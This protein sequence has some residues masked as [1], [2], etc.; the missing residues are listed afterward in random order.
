MPDLVA[1]D[2]LQR[3]RT[4]LQDAGSTRW[5]LTEL[6]DWLND[7]MLDICFHKPDACSSTDILDLEE[8][9]LQ[10]LPDGVS[11]LLRVTRNI[12]AAGPPRV[13]GKVIKPIV[14]DIL[15]NQIPGWHDTSVVPFSAVVTHVCFDSM[16]KEHYYVFPGNTGTGQIE[17]VVAKEPTK[18]TKPNPTENIEGYTDALDIDPIYQGVIIDFILHRAFS[19]DMQLAGAINRAD[20]HY[21]RYAS[22]L[23]LRTQI[24][25]MANVNTQQ[26]QPDS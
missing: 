5:L 13:A 18:V 26:S 11:Q 3:A 10:T 20:M 16:D 12:T 24:E 15:D 6:C 22:A 1:S 7:A 9:T 25:A 2:V 8:G 23:G 4:I 21:Q 19:K 17:A 14:R